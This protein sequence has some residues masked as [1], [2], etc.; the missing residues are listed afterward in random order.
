MTVFRSGTKGDFGSPPLQETGQSPLRRNQRVRLHYPPLQGGA[1]RHCLFF[2]GPLTKIL[3]QGQLV[4]VPAMEAAKLTLKILSY[5]Q[6]L[7]GVATLAQKTSDKNAYFPVQSQ[8][9]LKARMEKIALLR[10]KLPRR[11]PTPRKCSPH[12]S[13]RPK[14]R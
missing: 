7:A 12:C 13:R 6:H 8:T 1:R 2:Q 4:M 3:G 5:S 14:K 11:L 9:K 10:K